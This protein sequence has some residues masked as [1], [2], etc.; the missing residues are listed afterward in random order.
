MTV[1]KETP[2]LGWA[3]VGTGWV[4]RDFVVPAIRRTAGHALVVA[5]DRDPRALAALPRGVPT[6]TDLAAALATPGVDCVY[7]ATPNDAHA[8]VACAAAAAGKH[9]LC[10]KPM[11]ATLADARAMVTACRAHGVRCATAFDQRFHAAHR[12]LARLV[13]D[14]ALGTVT[15]VRVHYACWLPAGWSPSGEAASA[16]GVDNWRIDPA[17]AGGGAL[18]DLAP[19]GL[20]LV[21]TLLGDR[22]DALET[23]TQRRVHGYAVD[24][25]AVVVGR[26]EGG[27]LATLHVA[28]NCPDALP[29]RVLELIGTRARAQAVDTMGQTAGGTLTLADAATGAVRTLPVEDDRSPFELQIEAFGRALRG[30]GAAWPWTIEDDLRR[31]ALLAGAMR[32]DAARH[33]PQP[34]DV[35]CR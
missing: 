14:G 31:F 27:V 32:R 34:A 3:L 16:G 24:D 5:C 17:R 4:A 1:A 11:A 28:Y 13:R 33:R 21:E 19:H 18:V 7:V 26:T 20:D 25:G 22:W 10:E 30:D 15:Q 23:L 6:T 12:A 9:V 8:G 35:A 29:R 2:T